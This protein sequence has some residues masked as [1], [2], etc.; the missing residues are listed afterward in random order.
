M[1]K[2]AVLL[3]IIMAVSIIPVVSAAELPNE[4][5]GLNDNYTAALNSSDYYGIIN[6]GTQ[7]TNLIRNEEH[8]EQVCNIMASRLDQIGIAYEHLGDYPAAAQT[9]TEY[10]PYAEA[11]NL[12]DGLKIARA[13]VLQ[14]TPDIKA[15][16]AAPSSYQPVYYGAKNEP[17][18]GTL[19][20]KVYHDGDTDTFSKESCTLIYLEFGNNDFAWVRGVLEDARKNNLAVEFA[21]N[22]TH[23]GNDMANVRN[24]TQHIYDVL[25]IFK[26]Y[27]DIPIFLRIGAEMNIWSVPAAP[28]DF[29]DSFRY[30][31]GIAKAE[32]SNVAT[33]WSVAHASSWNINMDDY[34]PGDEYVDW[35]GISAYMNK[36]FL[37]QEWSDAEK[38]NEVVFSAGDSA[39]PVKLV[40]EI[41]EKYGSRKPIMLAESGASH[42]VRPMG[43]DTTDWAVTKLRQMYNYLPMVYPQIKLIMYFDVVMPNE[44]NDYALYSNDRMLSAY[45]DT[46]G[47]AVGLIAN[48]Y[49]SA[50]SQTFKELSDGFIAADNYLPL[51][52][53]VHTYGIDEP[54]VNYYIDGGWIGS[55]SALPYSFSYELAN[56]SNGVHT[57][58]VEAESYGKLLAKRDYTFTKYEHI[59]ININD[60]Y[61]SSDVPPIIENDRTLVPI[62]VVSE[63]LGANVDWNEYEQS[64]TITKDNL[65]AKLIL[66]DTNIYDA[67]NYVQTV[68]D[69]P[70]KTIN[71]R[72]MVPI[73]AVATLFGAAVDWDGNTNTVL[74]TTK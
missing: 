24:N 33:V 47:Q 72:T 52:T 49:N 3:A 67:N 26:E 18:S 28:S 13:K 30:I 32:C 71:D 20:G 56:I 74:I 46:T 12:Y 63:Y 29:I 57:L 58:T 62:R 41:V 34:Y 31:A 9:Y 15:Y 43:K 36:H 59:A 1:K 61:I 69:V 45:N 64:V 10:I 25:N 37:G 17:K 39:D 44:T 60:E 7:I 23:E 51:S 2:T 55:S 40:S 5:W 8:T 42:T 65:T 70:A 66:G 11:L 16:T 54:R 50:P 35:V 38:F 21:W 73:R 53:Y 22:F 6:Y 27:S 14:Y 4:F 19:F 68:I 48:S